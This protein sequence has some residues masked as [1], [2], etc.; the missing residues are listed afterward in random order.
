QIRVSNVSVSYPEQDSDAL[1]H[2]SLSIPK[3]AYVGF[4]GRTGSGKTTMVDVLLGI[5]DPNEGQVLVDGVDIQSNVRGW[6]AELGFVSQNI[7]L[8]DDTIARNVAFGV[9]EAAIESSRVMQALTDAQLSEFVESLPDGLE[10]V[11]GENGIRLSG[12][13]RQRLGI[14]R[15][16]YHRPSVLV[17]DEATSALDNQTERHFVEA[18]EGLQDDLTVILVAHRLSTVRSCDCLFVF[19]RGRIVASGTY[20]ELAEADPVFRELA[21]VEPE[22]AVMR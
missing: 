20:S 21:A 22:P 18:L 17:L 9:D 8:V 3:G 4:V 13:Q 7:F 19:E 1:E 14:A 12:G 5:L 15:A 16:L 11:V 10:T 2:V 6:R